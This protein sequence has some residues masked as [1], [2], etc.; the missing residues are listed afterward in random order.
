MINK[1][2]LILYIHKE[3]KISLLNYINYSNNYMTRESIDLTLLEIGYYWF[4]YLLILLILLMNVDYVIQ[5]I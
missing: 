1:N 2:E 3:G 5:K 4:G